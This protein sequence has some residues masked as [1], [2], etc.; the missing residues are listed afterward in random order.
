MPYNPNFA[1]YLDGC[2]VYGLYMSR[3]G[4]NYTNNF[5]VV[6]NGTYI[7]DFMGSRPRSEW[8]NQ[9][10]Y[11]TPT[12]NGQ[13]IC[14]RRESYGAPYLCAYCTNDEQYGCPTIGDPDYNPSAYQIAANYTSMLFYEFCGR[15]VD[16]LWLFTNNYSIPNFS[17]NTWPRSQSEPKGARWNGWN[18]RLG[19]VSTYGINEIR[20]YISTTPNTSISMDVANTLDLYAY[21]DWYGAKQCN[22]YLIIDYDED[23]NPIFGQFPEYV[24][25]EALP[26]IPG[27]IGIV[28]WKVFDGELTDALFLPLKS[29]TTNSFTNRLTYTSY[30]LY[31]DSYLWWSEANIPVSSVPLPS[32]SKNQRY[33]W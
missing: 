7:G 9:Y 26:G 32:W 27:C 29:T 28:R 10:I 25:P 24:Q 15:H 8:R 3:C 23:D 21:R 1:T 16:R 12:F 31:Q 13:I 18:T 6:V 20:G 4:Y 17:R 14:P 5:Q 19:G 30:P 11:G 33:Y 2:S 22:K